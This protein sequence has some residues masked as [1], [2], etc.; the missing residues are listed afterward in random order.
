MKCPLSVFHQSI[1]IIL[2]KKTKTCLYWQNKLYSLFTKGNSPTAQ[3]SCGEGITNLKKIKINLIKN[4]HP[5]GFL[6]EHSIIRLNPLNVFKYKLM[7]SLKCPM[8]FILL[9]LSIFNNSNCFVLLYGRDTQIWFMSNTNKPFY[10]IVN[11]NQNEMKRFDGLIRTTYSIHIC[12]KICE[13]K[14]NE[15]KQ[16][17]KRNISYNS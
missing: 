15:K 11:K 2:L 16:K 13:K 6:F 7:L 8:F 3:N 1:Q 4:W 5:I 12:T 9:Q 10:L 14:N 17:N